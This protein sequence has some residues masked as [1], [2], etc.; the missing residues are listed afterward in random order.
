M[1]NVIKVY[2]AETENNI[3]Q[4]GISY[5]VTAKTDYEQREEQ[6]EIF[7]NRLIHVLICAGIIACGWLLYILIKDSEALG[8]AF[9]LSLLGVIFLSYTGKIGKDGFE[10]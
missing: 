4:L 10:N 1:Q 9:S 8:I 7:H 5:K 3:Y 2:H 6:K